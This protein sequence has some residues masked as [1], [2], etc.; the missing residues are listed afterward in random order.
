MTDV[1]PMKILVVDDD[2]D[3]ADALGELF[4][5]EGHA[6]SVAY[7]GE[8]AV[9]AY[10]END[11]DIAFMDI[12]MPGKNGVES[13]FEI[14]RLKPDA[15]VYMMTGFSVEQLV[16]QAVDNGAMGV[17]SKPLDLK[18]VQTSL[19]SVKPA[20]VVLIAE[21]DPDL[22][23]Q[24]ADLVGAGG[25]A[26]RLVTNGQEA[27]Q[28]VECG[29]VDVLILDL[30]LPVID[31]IEVY[32]SLKQ[33]NAAP[34]TIIVTGHGGE[35]ANTIDAMRDVSVTGV[36]NKPFDPGDLLERLKVLAA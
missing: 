31:G 16:R 8:A 3:A 10:R 11:F 29:N 19:E 26:V 27:L 33:R 9:T 30:K 18:K 15:K 17:L 36:L 12:M 14:R 28:Q 1:E 20:G 21:D 34:P 5:M 23:P 4:E 24:L 7:N 22:G 35:H 32:T 25:Y 13:F 6:V 2:E